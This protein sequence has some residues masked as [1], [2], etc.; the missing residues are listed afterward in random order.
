MSHTHTQKKASK[1]KRRKRVRNKS[2]ISWFIAQMATTWSRVLSRL[3]LGAWNII[4]WG[5]RQETFLCLF[6]SLYIYLSNGKKILR[7]INN[8]SYNSFGQKFCTDLTFQWTNVWKWQSIFCKG[9]SSLTFRQ[10]IP[11]IPSRIELYSPWAPF[12]L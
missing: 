6:F 12:G 1:T 3:N 4:Q 2:F 7:N 5:R 9:W 10:W 11:S 8:I